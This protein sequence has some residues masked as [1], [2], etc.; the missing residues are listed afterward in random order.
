MLW[1]NLLLFYF[2]TSKKSLSLLSLG[3]QLIEQYRINKFVDLIELI[4]V[5][6]VNPDLD[7]LFSHF[8]NG[9]GLDLF[10]FIHHLSQP[11]V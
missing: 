10:D 6:V 4:F 5:K 11:M 9:L 3:R 8:C 1:L 7:F 2:H